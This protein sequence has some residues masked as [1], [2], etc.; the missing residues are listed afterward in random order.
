MKEMGW[1][2]TVIQLN[3]SCFPKGLQ[4]LMSFPSGQPNSCSISEFLQQNYFQSF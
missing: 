3:E 1:C 2:N 4:N